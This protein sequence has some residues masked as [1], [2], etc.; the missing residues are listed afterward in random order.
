[1]K[2]H[3]FFIEQNLEN[4]DDITIT[5]Q[6]VIHQ[7]KDV[8]RLRAG[9]PVIL[10]DG[11]GNMLHG[12]I[13]VLMK[14]ESIISKES[15]KKISKFPKIKIKLCSSMIKKDKYEW[16]LQKATE[17]GVTEFQPVL[18]GRTEKPNLN[19]DRAVKIIREAA[20]QSERGDLPIISDIENLEDVL[21][22]CE[23]KMIALHL[24]GESFDVSQ[25]KDVEN[26]CIFIGP[27]GG[28]T[29]KDIELFKG[30]DVEIVSLGKQ[31]LRAET[32]SIAI[33]ALLLL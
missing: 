23:T 2:T 17:L 31:V 12:Q 14:K 1:M 32:A 28:W 15:L 29:E 21:Q 5:N 30:H 18:S 33:A 19:M 4:T 22:K 3:R 9:D 27:E 7:M 25:Y 6:D 11:M 20:E 10:L 8:L 24:E 16:V 13:K 26:I